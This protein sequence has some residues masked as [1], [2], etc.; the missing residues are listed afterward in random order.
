MPLSKCWELLVLLERETVNRKWFL[1]GG[2]QGL[3]GVEVSAD[4]VLPH[5]LP[6]ASRKPLLCQLLLALLSGQGA[7]AADAFWEELQRFLSSHC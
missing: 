3:S 5:G 7:L 1:Q 6:P 2:G 4:L